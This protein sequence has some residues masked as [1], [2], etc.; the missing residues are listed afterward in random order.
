MVISSDKGAPKHAEFLE[1]INENGNIP[2]KVSDIYWIEKKA[3]T[4]EVKTLEKKYFIRK[5]LNELE[6]VLVP[7]GFIRINRSVLVNRKY[8][9]NY[10][11]WEYD[12]FI[13]RMKDEGD[14]EFIVSR[15]RMRQIKNQLTQSP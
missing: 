11:F 9:Y 5:T 14:T 7:K 4:Y 6:E 8:V 12:K 15:D 10:S 2:I 13:L 1:V 3:R